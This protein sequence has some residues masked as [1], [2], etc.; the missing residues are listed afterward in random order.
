[1]ARFRC[2]KTTMINQN[3]G[4]GVRWEHLYQLE[5]LVGEEA[6]LDVEPQET[7]GGE[8]DGLLPAEAVPEDVASFQL[9]SYSDVGR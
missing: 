9:H 3:A 1:M 8:G 4:G 5:V 6:A 7:V 2:K